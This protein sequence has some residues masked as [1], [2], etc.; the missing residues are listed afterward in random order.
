MQD[1]CEGVSAIFEPGS[2]ADVVDPGSHRG[3]AA[4]RDV[5][6]RADDTAHSSV[7]FVAPAVVGAGAAGAT[8][9][10]SAVAEALGAGPQYGALRPDPEGPGIGVEL[11]IE[12]V[13]AFVL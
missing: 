11:N 6:D 13:E 9:E 1:A 8:G 2:H 3:G 4:R 7:G 10:V 5:R 12:D